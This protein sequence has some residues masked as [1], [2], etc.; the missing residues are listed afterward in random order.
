M[1]HAAAELE[2]EP[3]GGLMVRIGGVDLGQGSDTAIA[4]IA[5]QSTGLPFGSVQ[6]SQVDAIH[7]PDGSI[8]SASRTTYATGNAVTEAGKKLRNR[9]IEYAAQLLGSDPAEISFEDAEFSEKNGSSISL[10][11]LAR[12]ADEK[13]FSLTADYHYEPA[14]TFELW[15]HG[16][17]N[18]DAPTGSDYFFTYSYATQIAV[19]DVDT[20]LG[21]VDVVKIIAA[22]D[23]G[24]AINP[25]GVE[26]QI[27]GSCLM[28]M[29]FAL[30]E[31]FKL[32][33]GYLVTDNL[34]KCHIPTFKDSPEI[35]PIIVEDEE[36]SGPFGAKGIAEAAAIPT[37]PAIINAVRNA[38]GI[39][40][41]DLPAT[42]MKI[43][44]AL[45]DQLEEEA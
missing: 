19:V 4:Q 28:G 7:S 10:N 35:V 6:V 43:L 12:L 24:R 34:R 27:E 1:D 31:E 38:V 44:D 26:A 36:P 32:D 8:T 33:N 42:P 14:P 40:M 9:L 30:T 2:L 20:R 15:P 18:P 23:V 45:H 22:H 29:G 37:A 16:P 17:P 41:R 13:G 3:N 5:A 39:T 21:Q 11:E 25:L